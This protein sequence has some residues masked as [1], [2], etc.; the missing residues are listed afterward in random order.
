[1]SRAVSKIAIVGVPTV[2]LDKFA[3]LAVAGISSVK[4]SIAPVIFLFIVVIILNAESLVNTLLI[5]V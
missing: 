1:V 5:L 4:A 2:R 3:A